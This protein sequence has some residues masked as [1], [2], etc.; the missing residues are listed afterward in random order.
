MTVTQNISILG[1][2][3]L[4]RISLP[5][6]FFGTMTSTQFSGPNVRTETKHIQR[7]RVDTSRLLMYIKCIEDIKYTDYIL[8]RTFLMRHLKFPPMFTSIT[9]SPLRLPG[10]ELS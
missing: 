8:R 5:M 10:V 1:Y 7:P 6:T 2:N 4:Q 9:M 3:N